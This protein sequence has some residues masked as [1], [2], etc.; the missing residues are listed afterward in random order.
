ML[1]AMELDNMIVTVPVKRFWRIWA[2]T[3][4]L[5]CKKKT[6]LTTTK[7][8]L[9]T[10]LAVESNTLDSHSLTANG[11]LILLGRFKD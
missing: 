4:R 5:Y 11:T 8:C 1:L 7:H 10:Y 3:Y 9:T 6:G 2:N